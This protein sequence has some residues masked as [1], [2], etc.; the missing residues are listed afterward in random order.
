MGINPSPSFALLQGHLLSI[1]YISGTLLSGLHGLTP[2]IPTTHEISTDGIIEAHL[3]TEE[4][5]SGLGLVVTVTWLGGLATPTP[6]Q[7]L[8]RWLR[9]KNPPA[10]LEMQKTWVQSLGWENPLQDRLARH[11][12][13]HALRRKSAKGHFGARAAHR[14]GDPAVGRADKRV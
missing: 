12:D 8:P 6:N 11:A 9:V 14:A 13:P 5:R 1:Y 2:L 4:E 7:G 10:V 3:N